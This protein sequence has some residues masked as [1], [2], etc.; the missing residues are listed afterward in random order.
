MQR[1]FNT[2]GPNQAD[3]S[4]TL[5]PLTRFDL[6]EVLLLIEQRRYFVLHAP[7]QTG[8]TTALL[9]LQDYLNKDGR[10]IC[11]YAN[12]EAA[13][14]ARNSVERAIRAIT[15]VIAE[16]AIDVIN[17]D[18]PK[19]VLVDLRLQSSLENE[20]A[21]LLGAWAR[22]SAKPVVLLLDE[23]DAL[24]GDALISVLRQLRSGYDKRPTGF[25]NTVVLCGVRDVRDYRIHTSDKEII[26]GGSAF[27]IK[28]VS[29]RLG[30]FSREQ[31][32]ALYAQH[33]TET[34][35]IFTREAL[36]LAWQLTQGQPWLVN[37]LAQQACFTDK[38]GRDRSQAINVQ[39]LEAAKE[40][41]IL[42]RDTHLDQLSDKLREP[43][44]R[45]IIEPL[46]AGLALDNVPDDDM[47][48]VIDLGL[49]RRRRGGG[50]EIANAIYKEIIPRELSKATQ[51][52]LPALKPAWLTPT[53]DL[54]APKLL[55]S[56]LA[57][58]R[59]HGQP[60]LKSAHYHEIAPHIVLMAFLHR[61][62]NG[63]GQIDREYAI[64]SRRMDLL[65]RYR[66]QRFAFELK[67]WRDDEP[68]P[69]IEGLEQLDDY[70][71][72]LGL[73][74]GWLVIFDRRAGL[75]PIAA[76]TLASETLTPLGRNTVVIRA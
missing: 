76:R 56:F 27:N 33:T 51:D 62:A 3:Q 72:G 47:Q 25:P 57:F 28:A 14:A 54:D 13:Q 46:L 41:L 24:I 74:T 15:T 18:F 39:R 23:I 20:L 4:Y 19:K 52:S 70:L 61:V 16:R 34:G 36:D 58:W 6:D 26:T 71:S 55:D 17:D 2:A 29:L 11:L 66:T 49:I 45:H 43:R 8:K 42:R 22:H 30:D 64:G 5:P 40:A 10:Y 69:L 38:S 48:Y 63:E 37:A 60:L 50:I 75:P 53:G 9:A 35:Q 7:R 73:D 32:E 59:Q 21:A 12:I 65:L 67:V 31:M 68:D 44:V 1:F